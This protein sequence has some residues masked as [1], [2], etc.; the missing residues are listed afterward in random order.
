[1]TA[2]AEPA[3]KFD[4]ALSFAGEDREYVEQVA[5]PLRSAGLQ[6]FYDSDYQADMWGEDLVEYFDQV[7]RVKARYAIMFISHYYA[8]KMWPRHERRS[9]LARAL[10]ERRAYILPVRLDDT[11]LEGL[12]PTVG[13]LD[14]RV[15]GLEGIVRTA[16]NKITGSAPAPPSEITRV[17]RTEAERQQILA[18]RPRGWEFLYFAGQLLHERNGVEDKY[19]D[20]EI[21]YAALT[22]EVADDPVFGYI[23]HRLN[24]AMSLANKMSA[25]VGNT[26][27]KERA[28]GPPGQ[29]GD[30]ERLAHLA[31]RWNSSYEEF[32]DWASRVRGVTAP[33]EY[34]PLLDLLACYADDPVEKYR[35]MV[36]E[37]VAKIDGIPAALA[38]GEQI[39]IEMNLT[40][41]VPDDLALAYHAESARIKDLPK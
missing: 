33:S 6:V 5:E 9:A 20:H 19:R 37:Y 2:D 35:R 11:P 22:G 29:A 8:T 1:M 36:D 4:V 40:I 13:Y 18:E 12:R 39:R 14:A 10:E 41:S 16:L 28:F 32:M 31:K 27:A 3:Y 26:A 34:H 17:P 15:V 21:Q 24:D 38:A 23:T 30:P 25:L 7:Y